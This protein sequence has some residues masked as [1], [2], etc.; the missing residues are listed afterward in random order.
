MLACLFVIIG[1]GPSSF[2]VLLPHMIITRVIGGLGIGIGVSRHSHVAKAR[3]V[4][5]ASWQA[6]RPSA[7]ARHRRA[8]S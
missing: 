7:R 4:T 5:S 1:G 8:L 6:R 2:V 3:R